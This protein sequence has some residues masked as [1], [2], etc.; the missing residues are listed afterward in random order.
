MLCSFSDIG[1]KIFPSDFPWVQSSFISLNVFCYM[2]QFLPGLFRSGWLVGSWSGLVELVHIVD[3]NFPQCELHCKL[4]CEIFGILSPS[5]L[6]VMI[7]EEESYC[8]DGMNKLVWLFLSSNFCSFASFAWRAACLGAFYSIKYLHSGPNSQS[9]KFSNRIRNYSKP[10]LLSWRT[11]KSCST[12][13]FE[14]MLV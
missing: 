3:C 10:M 1:S 8:L 13:T 2:S 11:V 4:H 5:V 14:G 9:K 7:G 6:L 12:L